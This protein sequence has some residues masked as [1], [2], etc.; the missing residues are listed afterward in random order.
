MTEFEIG[1]DEIEDIIDDE[2]EE[3][4]TS[5][6]Q[7]QPIGDSPQALYTEPSN[8]E[9]IDAATGQDFYDIQIG[10]Q[11]PR[12]GEYKSVWKELGYEKLNKD[13]TGVVRATRGINPNDPK[14]DL[15]KFV[16]V[17]SSECK[18]CKPY[19]GHTYYKDDPDRPIIPRLESGYEGANY[20][21]PRCKCKWTYVFRESKAEELDP[22]TWERASKLYGGD[23]SSLSP[24]EQKVFIVGMLQK[25]LNAEEF[26]LIDPVP[27]ASMAKLAFDALKP[28]IQNKL[29]IGEAVATER[30]TVFLGQ[31]GEPPKYGIQEMLGDIVGKS[32]GN[33]KKKEIEEAVSDDFTLDN[34]LALTAKALA[35]KLGKKLGVESVVNEG[36]RGSGKKFHMPY[37]LDIEYGGNVRECENCMILTNFKDNICDI[38]KK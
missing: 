31:R 38:C 14:H 16:Y 20:T 4:N 9:P 3:V 34:L 5:Y 6:D 7:E 36:G 19:D 10:G 18:I 12:I 2:I 21:H 26:D 29:G 17:S 27:F 37:Q 8:S 33:T 32:L 11:A 28:T 23:F 15:M 24:I 13:G 1:D 35:D 22:A 30:G 25:S